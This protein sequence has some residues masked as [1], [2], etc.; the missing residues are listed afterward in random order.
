MLGVEPTGE[1]LSTLM[2]ACGIEPCDV[3][4]R[5][6]AKIAALNGAPEPSNCEADKALREGEAGPGWPI[7]QK[8]N[9]DDDVGI[10]ESYYVDSGKMVPQR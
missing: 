7:S 9:Q 1:G 10:R 2:A 3:S 4:E 8:L 5:I 6:L